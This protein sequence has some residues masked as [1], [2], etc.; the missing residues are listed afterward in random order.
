MIADAVVV[1]DMIEFLFFIFFFFLKKNST[2][3]SLDCGA[4]LESGQLIGDGGIGV[5]EHA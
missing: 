2:N 1:N 4:V 5:G 3:L